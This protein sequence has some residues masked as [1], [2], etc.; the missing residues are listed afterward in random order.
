MASDKYS[1]TYVG[2]WPDPLLELPEVDVPAGKV[3]PLWVTVHVPAKTPAGDY[4]GAVT[5]TARDAPPVEV[6]L[7]VTVWGFSLPAKRTFRAMAV[8]GSMAAPVL[9]RLLANHISPAYVMRAWD[10]DKPHSPVKLA[11]GQWDFS[12]A[13]QI[14]KY[15]IKR[16]MNTFTIARFARPGQWGFPATYSA[17]YRQRFGDFLTAYTDHLRQNGW[18]K[19]GHVYNIDEAPQ[20]DWDA[21]KANAQ[22]VKAVAPDVNVMQCLNEPAG[23]RA[24]AGFTDIWDVYI[25]QFVNSAVP[26]RMQA[27]DA[28]IFALCC[29]PS[30]HP[31]L[32]IDYPAMDA[33]IIGWMSWKEGISG[34][35][36][37]N[38]TSWGDNLKR[39][40][41]HPYLT[42]I[43]SNWRAATFGSYN[44][45]GY[46][47]YPGPGG[48][49]L[50][51]IRLANLRDGFQDY[52]M[53][54]MLKARVD[55][56]SKR[57]DNVSGPQKALA[58]DDAVCSKNLH[59]TSRPD[60]LLA[61][62]RQVADWIVRLKPAPAE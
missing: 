62:R 10:W 56:A 50:S 47:I 11:N 42:D 13:D 48:T 54:A 40:G 21:C 46:L 36:Y 61:A 34:F 14:G 41:A 38:A 24:L 8:D 15:C 35:E 33:R 22:E 18:L 7:S 60:V 26:Q 59:Y 32:F 52:E 19:M 28:A 57:G 6:A 4:S 29:Y 49:A 53:L 37:W 51:S 17:D 43:E 3:Q 25:G 16:G 45:D 23:V 39:L 2:L 30:S 55:A 58:V 27:G 1:Q 9:N 12:Q 5:L 20:K 31:N 44:G